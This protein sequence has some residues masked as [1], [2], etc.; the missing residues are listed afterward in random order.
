MSLGFIIGSA[1]CRSESHVI[2]QNGN[3]YNLKELAMCRE[4]RTVLVHDYSINNYRF[5]S[6]PGLI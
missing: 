6:L 5:L 2:S 3:S 1:A 4:I